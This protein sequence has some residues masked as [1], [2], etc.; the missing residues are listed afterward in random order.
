MNIYRRVMVPHRHRPNCQQLATLPR[1]YFAIENIEAATSTMTRRYKI[2]DEFLDE[3][4]DKIQSFVC[5]KSLLKMKMVSN[6]ISQVVSCNIKVHLRIVIERLDG[7]TKGLK[8]KETKNK[9]QS[10]LK[11]C[12]ELVGGERMRE[13]GYIVK[14]IPKFVHV[15]LKEGLFMVN[16]TIRKTKNQSAIHLGP[17]LGSY[18]YE[19]INWSGFHHGSVY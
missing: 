18:A 4:N 10:I 14:I 15:A 5:G 9:K 12:V 1:K 11:N 17:F 3:I 8:A 6:E 2:I 19:V 13:R 7:I 16:P